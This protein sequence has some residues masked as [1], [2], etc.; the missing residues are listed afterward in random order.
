MPE[1]KYFSMPSTVVGAVALRNEALNWTPSVLSLT[2]PPLAWTNSPAE[3]IAACPTR[4]MRSRWPRALTRSI[5]L[6]L[7]DGG[8]AGVPLGGTVP[9]QGRA[10]S[11]RSAVR[12]RPRPTIS[13]FSK[14][15]FPIGGDGYSNGASSHS[16]RG[17]HRVGG[18]VDHRD[19]VGDEIIRHVGEFPIGG[20]GYSN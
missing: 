12:P 6:R 14:A 16:D 5:G 15:S 4:V 8:A 18:R 20:D 2:Q 1:P 9:R 13:F 7:L 17:Y 19:A 10:G 11:R 3:I